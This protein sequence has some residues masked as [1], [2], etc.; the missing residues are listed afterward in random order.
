MPKPKG[1]NDFDFA[2][3]GY[4]YLPKK[5][6]IVRQKEAAERMYRLLLFGRSIFSSSNLAEFVSDITPKL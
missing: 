5:K 2:P 4:M 3:I 6:I 1:L